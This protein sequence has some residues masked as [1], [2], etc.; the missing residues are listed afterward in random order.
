MSKGSQKNLIL[1][2]LGRTFGRAHVP[3]CRVREMHGRECYSQISRHVNNSAF[4]FTAHVD[5][6]SHSR[7]G[8]CEGAISAAD[9]VVGG[10]G[11]ASH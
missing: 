3:C 6:G 2:F 11:D 1:L 5:F 4:P 9:E 7:R 10:A 8:C